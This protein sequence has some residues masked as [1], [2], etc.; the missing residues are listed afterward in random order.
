MPAWPRVLPLNWSD[1]TFSPE[2]NWTQKIRL[3]FNP[4]EVKARQ[5]CQDGLFSTG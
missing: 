4:F 5:S 3:A 2:T 1:G